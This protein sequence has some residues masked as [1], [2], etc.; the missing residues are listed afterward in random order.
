M[1]RQSVKQIEVDTNLRCLRVY[2]VEGSKKTISELKTV[3][4]KLS[5][6]QAIHLARILL[7][8]AQE[9]GE[10]EITAYRTKTRGSDNTYQI[11]V[12]SSQSDGV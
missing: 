10:L 3:G 8:A 1:T 11:T 5:K 2:P 9:W 6:E 7:V 4:L 12:T